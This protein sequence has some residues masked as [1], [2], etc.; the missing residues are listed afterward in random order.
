MSARE[1]AE[2]TVARELGITLAEVQRAEA[3]SAAMRERVQRTMYAQILQ[4]A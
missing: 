4:G 3:T 2:R 1:Q